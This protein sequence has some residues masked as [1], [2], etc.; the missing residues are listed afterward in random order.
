M[1]DVNPKTVLETLKAAKG[2]LRNVEI[3]RAI[4]GDGNEACDPSG[5]FT[6]EALQ[7]LKAEGLVSL[8]HGSRWGLVDV[9]DCPACEGKGHLTKQK[10]AKLGLKR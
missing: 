6:T 10:A 1:P 2:P 9:I 4:L 3:R 7:K 5:A 8:M